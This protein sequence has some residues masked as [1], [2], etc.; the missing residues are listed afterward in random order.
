MWNQIDW[1]DFSKCTKSILF[2]KLDFVIVTKI[3]FPNIGLCYCDKN[4]ISKWSIS[5]WKHTILGTHNFVFRTYKIRLLK[6]IQM[7]FII[8]VHCVCCCITSIAMLA[9]NK[10]SVM[11]VKR[12]EKQSPFV[13]RIVKSTGWP[14]SFST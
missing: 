6:N 13:Y 1:N 5:L 14:Q 2:Q 7:E 4:F 12:E 10:W 8:L 3:S 9:D 11:Q